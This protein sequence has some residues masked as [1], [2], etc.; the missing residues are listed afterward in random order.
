MPDILTTLTSHAVSVFRERAEASRATPDWIGVFASEDPVLQVAQRASFLLPN[1]HHA[2][3]QLL[4]LVFAEPDLAGIAPRE[5]ELDPMLLHPN[6]GFRISPAGLVT[7]LFSSA[8]LQMYYL[9]LPHEEG[10][11]V[12]TVLEGFEELRRAARGER[13][14]AYAITGLARISLP[15]GMQISTP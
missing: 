2:T 1:R 14:R 8:L 10:T 3:S 12:R 5:G 7:S 4:D 15:E 9:H 13:V 6:G 11:F